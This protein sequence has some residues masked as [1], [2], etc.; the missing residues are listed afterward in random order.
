MKRSRKLPTKKIAILN[1]LILGIMEMDA[2]FGIS[3]YVGYRVSLMTFHTKIIL[4]PSVKF[5]KIPKF[6]NNFRTT[7]NRAKGFATYSEM[8]QRKRRHTIL[9]QEAAI[10]SYKL[11][12][13]Q[14]QN[15]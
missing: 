15:S 4:F 13:R 10:L 12:S 1:V 14:F 5:L 9:V 11:G 7:K 8:N 3:R 6:L 2:Y